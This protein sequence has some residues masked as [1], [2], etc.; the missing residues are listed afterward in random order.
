ME[1]QYGRHHLIQVIKVKKSN[2]IIQWHE[3]N[4][5]SVIYLTK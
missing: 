2:C 4:I 3:H 5:I 1:K